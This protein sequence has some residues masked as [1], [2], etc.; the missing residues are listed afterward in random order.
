MYFDK[1]ELIEWAESEG[2][3]PPRL[4]SLGFSHNN[5]GGGCVR[6]GQGQ[7]KKLLEVMPERFAMWE[8][9]EQEVREYLDKDVAILSE[10]KNG[11]KKP[12]PLIE[13]RRRVEDQPQLVDDDD[14]GGCGCFF[15]EDER[16]T[17]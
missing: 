11:I 9:K 8:Q 16:G 3:T 14:L 12:L 4:Y 7:F 1:P 17:E 13:L 6:A 10:V 5:C 2:L 15:E